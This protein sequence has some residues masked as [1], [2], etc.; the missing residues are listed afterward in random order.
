MA[1][2]AGAELTSR[3]LRPADYAPIE[4]LPQTLATKLVD[5]LKERPEI[6]HAAFAKALRIQG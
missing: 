5:E 3:A 6:F 1:K 2:A 4:E